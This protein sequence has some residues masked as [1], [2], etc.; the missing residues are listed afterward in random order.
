MERMKGDKITRTLKLYTKLMNGHLIRKTEEAERYGVNERSIQRD[1][2]DI[3]SFLSDE[4]LENGA[5][6]M[7]VYDRG[8]KGYRLDQ[9]NK[10]GLTSSE[11][12]AVC[13]ILL[14]SRA[15]TKKEMKSMLER[16]VDCCAPEANRNIVGDLIR[17][18]EFHYVEPR[19][20]T[21]FIDTMWEIGLAIRT[22][23]YIEIR[24]ERLKDRKKVTRKVKPAA[25]MFSEYY[26]YLTAFID[27]ADEGLAD[28]DVVND[29]FPTIYR[30]DRIRKLTV[31]DEQFN[32]PYSSR[33]QEGE[34]RK[35]VQ[36]MYGGRLQRV[37]FRYTGPDVDA[38]L[39]RLPT[40]E[41]IDEDDEGYTI[42]AEVFGKG[43]DMWFR[44]QGD[45]IKV[46]EG[47]DGR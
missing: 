42:S 46:I 14:D 31:L 21:T 36:F 11:I 29:S 35:R 15:F 26:F 23:H 16:L 30:I 40:A 4:T 2:D 43:I 47:G 24:Y 19:H 5:V 3:R 20:K 27:D 41:I 10:M 38:V 44:S 12:L 6:N 1:I 25:I 39:D 33:F 8:K 18:E 37:R 17:N 28:F 34:F 9:S 32:I 22:F 7:I 13:K 45:Y